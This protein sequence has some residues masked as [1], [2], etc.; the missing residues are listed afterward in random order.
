ME[1]LAGIEIVSLTT[2][3]AFCP[4]KILN[5]LS[6]VGPGKRLVGKPIQDCVQVS[7]SWCSNKDLLHQVSSYSPPATVIV[8]PVM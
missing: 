7:R 5:V 2:K 1:P 4:M 6:Q 3:F 8:E